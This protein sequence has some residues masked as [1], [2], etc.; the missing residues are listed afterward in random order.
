MATAV[1]RL[2]GVYPRCRNAELVFESGKSVS[3]FR[4]CLRTI[5]GVFWVLWEEEIVGVPLAPTRMSR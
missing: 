2:N 1:P 5:S 3:V 4:D